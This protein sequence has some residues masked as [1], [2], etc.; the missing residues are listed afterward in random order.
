MITIAGGILLALIAV[1]VLRNLLPIVADFFVIALFIG[2]IF[3]LFELFG[4][5]GFEGILVIVIVAVSFVMLLLLAATLA[6]LLW[7]LKGKRNRNH[8]LILEVKRVGLLLKPAFSISAKLEK[9]AAIHSI[10]KEQ[11]DR[12]NAATAYAAEGQ[13]RLITEIMDEL[14]MAIDKHFPKGKIF[15]NRSADSHRHIVV[16]A[17]IKANRYIPNTEVCYIKVES[18]PRTATAFESTYVFTEVWRSFR[19]NQFKKSAKVTK[20]TLKAILRFIR[21][22]PTFLS[23]KEKSGLGSEKVEPS[24]Y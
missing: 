16:S 5:L 17:D 14:T 2:V 24:L 9:T 12:E 7:S 22:H 8:S 13:E 23:S 3:L 11:R 21:M 4:W 18:I 15:I 20:A 1:S 6:T 19:S 10:E